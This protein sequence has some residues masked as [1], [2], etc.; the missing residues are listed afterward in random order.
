MT[1]PSTHVSP[2]FGGSAATGG[3][4]P[5]QGRAKR[6]DR[7]Q[8]AGAVIGYIV[9]VAMAILSL[10]PFFWMIS[11]SLKSMSSVFTIP[12]RL[13]PDPV[14]WSNYLD[15]FQAFPFFDFTFN[16]IFVTLSVTVGQV[17]TCAMAAYAFARMKFRGRDAIFLLYLGTMMIPYQVTLIPTYLL[18]AYFGW[19]DSYK[20]LIIPGILGGVYGTFLIRQSF[21]G[22][23]QELE[24]AAV[25]DGASP[26][27]IFRALMLPLSKPVLATYA[28]FTFMATWNDFLWPL[29]MINTPEKMTLTLGINLMARGRYTTD[30][31]HLMAGT[32]MSI[33]PILI[34]LVLLQRYFVEGITLTGMKA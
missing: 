31:P 8:V 16:T 11:T 6:R 3:R 24:D 27:W 13:I 25:I 18:M 7:I 10:F 26:I 17:L 5:A 15:V 4:V 33:I 19:I 30:W 21:L 1:S 12:P 34:V 22:I 20:A 32:C 2:A 28:V 23:P 29:L 14:L 9:M